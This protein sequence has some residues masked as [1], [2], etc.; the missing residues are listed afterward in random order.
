MQIRGSSTDCRSRAPQNAGSLPSHPLAAPRYS[1][2]ARALVSCASG[3]P[4]A[5]AAAGAAA[6]QQLLC[7]Q[8]AACA[9]AAPAQPRLLPE[10]ACKHVRR[11]IGPQRALPFCI[12]L[13]SS[14]SLQ[15]LLLLAAACGRARGR[16]RG[17]DEGNW[18]PGLCARCKPQTLHAAA[19]LPLPAHAPL[20][21][22]RPMRSHHGID[23]GRRSPAWPPS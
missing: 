23:R 16:Q 11:A 19:T 21:T 20:N 22:A 5:A 12:L 7:M 9:R 13:V 1:D 10:V 2:A 17:R 6:M 18:L 3:G 4:A 14:V 15:L 8:L